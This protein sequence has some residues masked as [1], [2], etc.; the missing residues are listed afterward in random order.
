MA[1]E[2]RVKY[3]I[4][5]SAFRTSHSQAVASSRTVI[6]AF[7]TSALAREM[8]DLSPTLRFSPSSSRRVSRLNFPPLSIVDLFESV[9]SAPN[10]EARRIASC[11][12]A[13]SYSSNGSKQFR[14][15]LNHKTR[16]SELTMR[17]DDRRPTTHPA[18]ILGSCGMMAS[19]DRNCLKPRE[20]ISIP[21]ILME[22]VVNLLVLI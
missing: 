3:V 20:A 8:R 21:S 15:V 14:I 9:S 10:N 18:N 2:I 19:F 1:I 22:P 16:V 6:F 13:S 12:R 5:V 17:T 4:R 11:S 7:L